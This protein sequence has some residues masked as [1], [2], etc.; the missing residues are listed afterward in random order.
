MPY[1]KKAFRASRAHEIR[2]L[3]RE[4]RSLRREVHRLQKELRE[5]SDKENA[6]L[7]RLF[8]KSAKNTPQYGTSER[9][10]NAELLRAPHVFAYLFRTFRTSLFY[11]FWKRICAYARRYRLTIL[12]LQIALFLFTLPKNGAIF[13]ALSA[14][15]AVLFPVLSVLLVLLLQATSLRKRSETAHFFR[16]LAQHK[17]IRILVLSRGQIPAERAFLALLRRVSETED[18]LTLVLSPYLFSSKSIGGTFAPHPYFAAV[19]EEAPRVFLLRMHFFYRI[20]AR[21]SDDLVTI[22]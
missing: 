12:F 3:R 10:R 9:L 14:A 15:S 19:R 16:V 4:N 21:L 7:P 17:S 13:L 20:R 5:R 22:Y 1:H 18:H 8:R 11:S 2:T 6:T